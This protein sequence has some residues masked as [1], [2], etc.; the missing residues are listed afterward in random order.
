MKFKN[1]KCEVKNIIKKYERKNME[2]RKHEFYKKFE[3]I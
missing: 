2:L 3:T 1:K